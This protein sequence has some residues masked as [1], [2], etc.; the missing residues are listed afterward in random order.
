MKFKKIF[1]SLVLAFVV[2]I[3]VYGE[4]SAANQTVYLS[5]STG[6]GPRYS[7]WIDGKGDSLFLIVENY[8][9]KNVG[10]DVY[11]SKGRVVANGTITD[12]GTVKKYVTNNGYKY[13]VR[14]RCQEPWWNDTK[15]E[16]YSILDD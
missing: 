14:L 9:N 4:A 5:P 7:N 16:A 11:D 12:K 6:S 13:K 2:V 8:T 10:Y 1:M 15:C 3:S